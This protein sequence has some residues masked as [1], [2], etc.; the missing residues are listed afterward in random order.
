MLVRVL[1][2]SRVSVLGRQEIFGLKIIANGERGLKM[3]VCI[4][5]YCSLSYLLNDVLKHPYA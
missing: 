4:I 2:F 3:T 1:V 5:L